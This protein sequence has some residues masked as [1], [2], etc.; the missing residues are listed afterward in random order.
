[1]ASI[2]M[3]MSLPK[4]RLRKKSKAAPIS[5][6]A[7]RASRRGSNADDRG[8]P[9]LKGPIISLA[10][11]LGVQIH[12]TLHHFLKLLAD[13]GAVADTQKRAFDFGRCAVERRCLEHI[14]STSS[15]LDKK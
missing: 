11:K 3:D 10:S 9:G 13:G 5:E 12:H 7:P 6:R 1:M 2:S 15:Y 14:S 4:A 8:G